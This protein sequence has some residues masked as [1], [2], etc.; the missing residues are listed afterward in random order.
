MSQSKKRRGLLG[1][2]QEY[3][4][5][6]QR[7][8]AENDPGRIFAISYR[9][10]SHVETEIINVQNNFPGNF[11]LRISQIPFHCC[12]A[13]D[14]MR[15]LGGEVR[16]VRAQAIKWLDWEYVTPDEVISTFE[17]ASGALG[18]FHYSGVAYLGGHDCVVHAEHYTVAFSPWCEFTIYHHPPY[19]SERNDHSADCRPNYEKHIGPDRHVFG[20]NHYDPLIMT[21]FLQAVRTGG[22]MAVPLL[23]GYKVAELAGAIEQSCGAGGEPVMLPL[24]FD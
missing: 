9:W 23:D 5:A 4:R 8:M 12:H 11:R 6:L 1:F 24:S 3:V 19:L 15:L 18:S 10:F 7:Y 16:S 22:P 14:T 21:D 20:R 17:F 13:L 2:L